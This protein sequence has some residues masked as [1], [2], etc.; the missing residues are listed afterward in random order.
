M[1]LVR[2]PR[3]ARDL[4]I[5]GVQGY[6]LHETLIAMALISLGVL[7]LA[8]NTNGVIRGNHRSDTLTVATNLA[9]D[10]IEELKARAALT[11]LNNCAL[12]GTGPEPADLK[13]T[14]SGDAGGIYDRCWA[15]QDSILGA[16]LKQVDVTV[17]WQDHGLR[18]V[19]LSTLVY[20][21]R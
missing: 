11:N 4:G 15:I 14:A 7:G 10:R 8:L 1:E 12:P 6:T 21:R 13:I 5:A 3:L 2:Q 16:H 9:Q 20:R 17:S 18:D 19:T